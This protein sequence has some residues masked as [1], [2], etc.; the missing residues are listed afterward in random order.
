MLP[1]KILHLILQ[2]FIEN[3]IIH[4]LSGTRF[5][6]KITVE[7]RKAGSL[8]EFKVSDNGYGMSREMVESLER[9]EKIGRSYGIAN[10]RERISLIYGASGGVHFESELNKGTTVVITVSEMVAEHKQS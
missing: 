3:S 4:G 9:G 10:T 5:N 7:C 6:N 8:L 1:V 2:P